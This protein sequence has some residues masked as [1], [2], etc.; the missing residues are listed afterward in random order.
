[1]R[2][3]KKKYE[4]LCE[5]CNR[6]FLAYPSTRRGKTVACSKDCASHLRKIANKGINNSN[7]KHGKFCEISYCNC[8]NEKDYRSNKCIDCT[9]ILIPTEGYDKTDASII[10]ATINSD[11]Y[12]AVSKLCGVDRKRVKERISSL[13][14]DISHF[15]TCRDRRT[16]YEDVFKIHDKRENGLVRKYLLDFELI[17]YRCGICSLT[18]EWMGKVLVLQLDHI[19]GNSRDNRIGNLRWLC[20]NCHTQTPTYCGRNISKKTR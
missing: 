4:Y 3:Q 6:P 13:N 8:G 18:D 2:E 16:K 9:S 14:L 17:E 19:N 7:Y 5:H 20:P 11:S 15:S 10:R 1:M 12:F